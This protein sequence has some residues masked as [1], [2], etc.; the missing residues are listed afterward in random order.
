MRGV[1]ALIKATAP[2][3]LVKSGKF[4]CFRARTASNRPTGPKLRGITKLLA[5]KIHSSTEPPTQSSWRGGAWQGEGGGLRRGKAVDAQVSRLAA[6]SVLVRKHARM[7]KLTR[8]FFGAL[9]YHGLTPVGS[10]RVVIDRERA[11]G[12]AVDVVCMRGKCE[13]VLV[14]LKTGFGGDRAKAA[15]GAFMQAPLKKAKD[16]YAN[17][18]FAQLAVTMHLFNQEEETLAKLR[19]KGVDEVSGCVLYVDGN[20]S[21]K[22]ELPE[23]WRK[24]GGRIADRI[25]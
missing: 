21:E 16:C 18:H 6:S 14:E 3:K 19:A 7:L 10:Q 9:A 4:A 15:P 1:K 8:L 20:Q 2:G 5:Q 24:R 12:T 25:C 23:W 13:L 17:R 11:I 22:F